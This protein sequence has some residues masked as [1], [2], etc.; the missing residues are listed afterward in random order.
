MPIY[1][2][3]ILPH[4]I[5]LACGMDVIR[6]KRREL[7]PLAEGRVLE[8]GMGSGLN[9]PYYDTGKVEFVWGLEPSKG[10]R[11]KAQR[12]LDNSPVEVKWLDLPGEEIPL[13]DASADTVVLTFTLCSIDGWLEAVREMRRVLKP[14]GK[15]IFCEHGLAPDE[16][17]RKWQNRLN[18]VWK[19]LAGGCNL[20]RDVPGCLREGGFRISGMES[21]Y[22]E[23]PSFAGFVYWG[24][25][26][27]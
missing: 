5:N 13:E 6:K 21:D 11:R 25:A 12:N 22:L 15:M 18:P 9:L 20:N 27:L 24:R 3:Y 16:N 14:G 10:M 4:L 26:G 17:I 23:S 8:V 1:E 7:V 2:N 19:R